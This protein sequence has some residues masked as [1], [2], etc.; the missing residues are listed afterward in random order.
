MYAYLDENHNVVTHT[1]I[2][3]YAIR[4]SD[5]DRIVKQENKW[6]YFVSTV[7]LAI[8]H[9]WWWEPLWFETM[10]FWWKN[11]EV[12]CKRYPTWDKAVEWHDLAVKNLLRIIIDDFFYNLWSP[13][14]WAIW[15]FKNKHFP[16]KKPD[17]E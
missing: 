17:L 11:W 8:D 9:W 14:K 5:M 13:I 12:Y 7:F 16:V 3:T 10:I 2:K 6:W 1:D 4:F 15:R